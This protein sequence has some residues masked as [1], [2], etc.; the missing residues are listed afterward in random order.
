MSVLDA[1][2]ITFFSFLFKGCPLYKQVAVWDI[3]Y[4][5]H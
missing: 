3:K 5:S 4:K 1:A 2:Q